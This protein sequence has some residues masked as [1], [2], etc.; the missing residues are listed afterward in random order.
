M[1]KLLLTLSL[2]GFLTSCS[3]SLDKK[4]SEETFVEDA[5]EIKESGD[6]TDEE[7]QIMASWIVRAKL[8]AEKLEGKTYGEIVSIRLSTSFRI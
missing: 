5:K 3:D 8:K 2:I 4:Y 1:K 6:L 7:V